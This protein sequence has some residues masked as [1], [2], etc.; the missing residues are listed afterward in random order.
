MT[1]GFYD[2]LR[3]VAMVRGKTTQSFHFK[4]Y[5]K[6]AI[7][8]ILMTYQCVP[9]P[10]QDISIQ[11]YISIFTVYPVSIVNLI[12]T[13]LALTCSRFLLYNFFVTTGSRDKERGGVAIYTRDIF[14]Y[15]LRD[16]DDLT[17][18]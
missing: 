6:S 10:L 9:N 5:A 18:N 13:M 15:K 4:R 7:I 3:T 1:N 12:R 8:M 16:G 11:Q 17:M 14:Q 2:Y